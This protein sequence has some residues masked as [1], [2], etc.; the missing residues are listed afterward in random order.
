LHDFGFPPVLE[1]DALELDALD[2]LALELD[3]TALEL[4]PLVPA[5]APESTPASAPLLAGKQ[6]PAMT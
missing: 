5:S 6:L 2:E 4:A 3:A 1:L